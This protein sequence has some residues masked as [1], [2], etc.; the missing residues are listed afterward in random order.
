MISNRRAPPRP[1]SPHDE[2]GLIAFGQGSL[3]S[4]HVV[5][6]STPPGPFPLPCAL[7]KRERARVSHQVLSTCQL[8]ERGRRPAVW[9]LR[10]NPSVWQIFRIGRFDSQSD[11][12]VQFPLVVFVLPIGVP[13]VEV[14]DTRVNLISYQ[15]AS[16]HLGSLGTEKI[17]LHKFDTMTLREQTN[18]ADQPSAAL[19]TSPISGTRDG[20]AA[21]VPSPSPAAVDGDPG[22]A[23]CSPEA[24]EGEAFPQPRLRLNIHDLDHPGAAKFLGAVNAATV[25]STA[26]HKVLRLLYRS[27]SDRHTTVPPTRSVTLVLRDMGGVAYTTGVGS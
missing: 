6:R 14:C 21:S 15:A 12:D 22:P 27:P 2:V 3:P 24:E 10:G 9:P 23:A 17:A 13:C 20:P 26:V 5:Q 18:Q 16:T 25:L 19:S 8:G 7:K 1:L 4:W 11:S